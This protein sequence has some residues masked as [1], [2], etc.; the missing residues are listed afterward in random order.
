MTEHCSRSYR[1][2]SVHF[3]DAY[4]LG[5]ARD[6]RSRLLARTALETCV[7]RID[8]LI[9]ELSEAKAVAEKELKRGR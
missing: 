8:T 3:Y 2:L 6:A 7:E 1:A 5:K 9:E 4:R